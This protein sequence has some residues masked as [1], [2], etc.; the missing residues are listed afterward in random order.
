[1]RV[2][3]TSGKLASRLHFQKIADHLVT[4]FGQHGLRVKL[5]ALNRQCAMAQSHDDRDA[6]RARAV[7]L[8]CASRD[9]ELFRK[10]FF[11]HDQE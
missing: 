7:R 9:F 3:R 8:R 2:S 4:A 1:M 5:Y 10:R 11:G 6:L